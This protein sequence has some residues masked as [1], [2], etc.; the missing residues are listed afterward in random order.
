MEEGSGNQGGLV[1]TM[2]ALKRLA[3]TAF[4]NGMLHTVALGA[5][6]SVRPAGRFQGRSTLLF[7]AKTLYEF[8]ER[9]T[10][11]K[12]HTIHRHGTPVSHNNQST[13]SQRRTK[14]KM[15]LKDR[16]IQE[17]YYLQTLNSNPASRG[18]TAPASEQCS[19]SHVCCDRVMARSYYLI[20]LIMLLFLLDLPDCDSGCRGFEPRQPPQ[21][22]QGVRQ[23]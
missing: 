19:H 3:R 23:L 13:I 15:R 5:M 2:A 20:M 17:F 18:H 12:L 22:K 6:K 8:G 10:F 14:P 11:L 21:I 16:A 1:T 9:Q 4:Q 7:R